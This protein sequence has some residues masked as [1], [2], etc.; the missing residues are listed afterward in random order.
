[1]YHCH[2]QGLAV[3]F[4]LKAHPCVSP[5][6]RLL[7]KWDASFSMGI[8]SLQWVLG[9]QPNTAGI[10]PIH[11]DELT[12]GS[13]KTEAGQG[14]VKNAEAKASLNSAPTT[15]QQGGLGA[16]AQPEILS[17]HYYID[18]IPCVCSP[19]PPPPCHMAILNKS[20]Y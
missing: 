13:G 5:P 4:Q 3:S 10:C 1:M 15:D 18:N 8:L 2:S 17:P 12:G 11:P 14:P 6:P 16:L 9:G 20:A 7:W 19:P